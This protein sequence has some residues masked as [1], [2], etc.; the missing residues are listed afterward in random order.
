MEGLSRP[1][2]PPPPSPSAP[3]ARRR[4]PAG[5]VVLVV[6]GALVAIMALAPLA[7]GAFLLWAH[8][9]QRDDEGFYTTS[10]E[11][12]ETTSYAITSDDID[13]G[14]QPTEG[15]TRVDLGDIATIRIEVE[16][17]IPVSETEDVKVELLSAT[18]PPTGRDVRDRRGVLAWA[19]DAKPGEAR[20]IKLA[21]RV[22]WPA[23]KAIVYAPVGR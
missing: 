3:A 7:G 20:E 9:T 4:V 21:W 18:T 5:W 22:R 14:A 16:D 15:N 1:A 8:A 6:V 17:Q 2:A 23:E 11:R 10:F 13:L 19:F 12:L